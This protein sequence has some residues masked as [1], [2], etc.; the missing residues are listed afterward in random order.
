MVA[1]RPETAR[2]GRSPDKTSI[3]IC[4]PL[5]HVSEGQAGFTDGDDHHHIGANT[6]ES[7][8]APPPPAGSAALRHL[9][10]VLPDEEERRRVL[11]RL[12]AVGRTPSSSVGGSPAVPDPSGNL[13]VL[14]AA[15]QAPA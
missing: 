4:A 7:A 11:G 13:V 9:T 15:A 14:E 5:G 3:P 8:G 10:V 6:W 2:S 12:A 1:S